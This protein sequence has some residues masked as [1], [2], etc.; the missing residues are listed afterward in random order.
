MIM[1]N[2]TT[3]L[4]RSFLAILGGDLYK[5]AWPPITGFG[6]VEKSKAGLYECSI[7]KP[8]WLHCNLTIHICKSEK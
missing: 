8:D 2:D 3:R 1:T 4:H 5:T 7:I 6:A